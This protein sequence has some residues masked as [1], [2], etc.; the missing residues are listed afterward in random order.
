MYGYGGEHIHLTHKPGNIYR[1]VTV[2]KTLGVC[3]YY[4]KAVY[5]FLGESWVLKHP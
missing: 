5:P 2:L 3:V 1:L 4:Q